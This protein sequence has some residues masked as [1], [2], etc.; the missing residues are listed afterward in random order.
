[1]INIIPPLNKKH[2]EY[3]CLPSALASP[4]SAQLCESALRPV[5]VVPTE[6]TTKGTTEGTT[7]G[8]A[9]LADSLA[10]SHI[11]SLSE[12]PTFECPPPTT[13]CNNNA[14]PAVVVNETAGYLKVLTQMFV[15]SI[16]AIRNSHLSSNTVI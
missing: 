2:D 10:D 1:M 8:T 12:L 7:E 14:N 4:S 5:S 13:N 15:D 3:K 11:D 9:I 6:G 16:V